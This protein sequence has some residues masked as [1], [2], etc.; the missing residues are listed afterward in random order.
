MPSLSKETFA[1][2]Q[3]SLKLFLNLVL[4][5]EPSI[6]LS[7]QPSMINDH[8]IANTKSVNAN[9]LTW[10]LKASYLLIAGCLLLAGYPSLA[11]STWHTTK[12]PLVSNSVN[13]TSFHTKS[14]KNQV[15]LVNFTQKHHRHQNEQHHKDDNDNCHCCFGNCV[16]PVYRATNLVCLIRQSVFALDINELTL[17]PHLSSH[18]RPPTFCV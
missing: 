1:F 10:I 6:V 5:K 7:E 12:T 11:S 15:T 2:N 9:L 14:T 16:P 18:L 8:S 17:P 3:K 4:F 13:I